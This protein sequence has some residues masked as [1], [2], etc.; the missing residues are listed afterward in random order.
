MGQYFYFQHENG[1]P[2]RQGL[3]CNGG[4]HWFPKLNYFEEEVM[5]EVFREVIELNPKWAPGRIVAWGD[6]GDV[7]VYDPDDNT[8]TYQ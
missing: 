5:I 7:I 6:S 8:I 3:V 2:N 4:L 1:T